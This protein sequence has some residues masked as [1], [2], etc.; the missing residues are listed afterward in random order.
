MKRLCLGWMFV[1][2]ADDRIGEF[3]ALEV[4]DKR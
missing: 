1:S 2:V 3:N 4:A